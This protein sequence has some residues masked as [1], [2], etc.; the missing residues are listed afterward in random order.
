MHARETC[1]HGPLLDS[2]QVSPGCLLGD[3]TDTCRRGQMADGMGAQSG[4]AAHPCG[5]KG[6]PPGG[7]I[8]LNKKRATPG[9]LFGHE[10]GRR[11]N[12]PLIFDVRKLHVR[13]ITHPRQK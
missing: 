11:A 2:G 12:L 8:T 10:R 5:R 6:N 4:G 1:A 3:S 9:S 13:F 7:Q